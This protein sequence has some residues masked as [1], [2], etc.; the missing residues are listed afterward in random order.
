MKKL[1]K[2][3]FY[4]CVPYGKR[5]FTLFF[6]M[7]VGSLALA[8]G[9]AIFDLTLRE[10]QLSAVATQSQYAIYAADT[11][12]ECA[13]YWDTKCSLG[14]CASGSVFAT[15][16]NTNGGTFPP[17]A[18]VVCNGQDVAATAVIAAT[19]PAASNANAATSSFTMY[20]SSQSQASAPTSCALVAV[21]KSGN[22]L[23]TTV[24]SHGY[25]TCT[26]GA[27]QLERTLQVSY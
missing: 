15:S 9:L 7:L 6:A 20:V 19:W 17:A 3:S 4:I 1:Y 24:V 12:A 25:N 14:G 22:P 23:H 2:L 8:V 13:L 21:S 18:G 11:G 5:G 16:T 27:L 10:L 26:P